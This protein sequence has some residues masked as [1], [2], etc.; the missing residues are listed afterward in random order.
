[1]KK[2]VLWLF[3][4]L[5]LFVLI[6]FSLDRGF[7]WQ[8]DNFVHSSFNF[9][10]EPFLISLSESF[11]I[12]FGTT[13]MLISAL[14]LAIILFYFFYK[15]EAAIFSFSMMVGAGI[16]FFFKELFARARP[17]DILVFENDFSFPSGH[18]L[19]GVIFF[20]FFIY[21][22][23][24]NIKSKNMRIGL[25]ILFGIMIL[26]TGLSRL[27]L[28][29]HWFSDVLGGF[30]LGEIIFLGTLVVSRVGLK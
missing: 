5:A 17:L 6:C 19:I 14:I 10:K 20:S 12:I 2:Q 22:T 7:L 9:D 8:I 26:L 18:S 30:L 16:T 3:I 4:L 23:S 28:N 1:M 25:Y 13:E 24:K 11:D 21:I 15:K 27:Y 29:A